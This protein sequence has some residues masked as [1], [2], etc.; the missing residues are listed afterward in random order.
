MTTERAKRDANAA[1]RPGDLIATDPAYLPALE[2]AREHLSAR[3]L[4]RPA[5]M[6]GGDMWLNFWMIS[7][8]GFVKWMLYHR[9]NNGRR[10]A[11]MHLL[12]YFVTEYLPPERGSGQQHNIKPCNTDGKRV[13][14]NKKVKG[15]NAWD[16]IVRI[17]ALGLPMPEIV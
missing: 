11:S 10:G 9:P 3:G 8:T 15:A 4:P 7:A 12:G 6:E 14:I 17:D 2:H 16:I 13:T 1:L 5:G